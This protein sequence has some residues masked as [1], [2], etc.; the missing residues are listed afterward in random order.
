MAMNWL[1]HAS[2]LSNDFSWRLKKFPNSVKSAGEP[3]NREKITAA[4][5]E[6]HEAEKAFDKEERGEQLAKAQ[7]AFSRIETY[8]RYIERKRADGATVMISDQE[9]T[10]LGKIM[11]VA[12]PC[13]IPIEKCYRACD[14]ILMIGYA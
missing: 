7:A 1:P 14:G 2:Q 11:I 12:I 13:W 8:R 5:E 3:S 10:L 4:Y 6:E 9:A